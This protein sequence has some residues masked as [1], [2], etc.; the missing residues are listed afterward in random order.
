MHQEIERFLNLKH[1]PGRLT[2]EQAASFLGFKAEEIPVLIGKGL[3]K[4]LIWLHKCQ[5][6]VEL[7]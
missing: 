7:L 2:R 1:L 5:E 3:L 4:P 6:Y